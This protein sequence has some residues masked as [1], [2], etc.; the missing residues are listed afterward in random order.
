LGQPCGRFQRA[1]AIGGGVLVNGEVVSLGMSWAECF[2][3][4]VWQPFLEEDVTTS[5][6]CCCGLSCGRGGWTGL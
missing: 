3:D 4:N 6:S 5:S 2:K 1:I